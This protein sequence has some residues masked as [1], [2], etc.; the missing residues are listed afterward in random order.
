MKPSRRVLSLCAGLAA[1]IATIGLTTTPSEAY[2]GRPGWGW[3]HPG[4]GWHAWGWG[5]GWRHPVFYP[6]FYP[7]PAIYQPIV[8]PRPVYLPPPPPRV[9]TRVVYVPTPV[10]H[11]H[12]YRHTVHK[13]VVHKSCS[14][15]CCAS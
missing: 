14:C 3:H 15:N 8:Y 1:L 2:W 5:W 13:A 9:Y 10:Y 11:R 7:A 12:Y 4:W 6:R